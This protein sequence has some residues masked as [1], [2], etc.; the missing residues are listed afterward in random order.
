[1]GK[2]PDTEI[3]FYINTPLTGTSSPIFQTLEQRATYWN[4]SRVAHTTGN[5]YVRRTTGTLKVAIKDLAGV[6]Y[7]RITEISWI[8]KNY[9]NHEFFAR[10]A[11]F[12][13]VSNGVVEFLFE[14]DLPQTWMHYAQFYSSPIDR[15][16]LTEAEY[17]AAVA[18]PWTNDILEMLTPEPDL[19]VARELEES[20]LMP[21]S[22]VGIDGWV[23]GILPGAA[24]NGKAGLLAQWPEVN[25][26][27]GDKLGSDS[28]IVIA[29]NMFPMRNSPFPVE[30]SP[31][32]WEELFPFGTVSWITPNFSMGGGVQRRRATGGPHYLMGIR[33]DG[34]AHRGGDIA[35]PLIDNALESPDKSVSHI[36]AVLAKNN[37]VHQIVS[38]PS[39]IPN[40]MCFANL[41]WQGDPSFVPGE[42]T[43][44]GRKII[45]APTGEYEDHG[46]PKLN[47]APFRYLRVK[48]PDGQEV[49]LTRERF[50][51]PTSPLFIFYSDFDAE[52]TVNCLPMQYD[53][54]D[55]NIDARLSFGAFPV[56]AIST[57]S[58]LAALGQ[59]K[60][61]ALMGALRPS[62]NLRVAGV[63]DKDYMDGV[64]SRTSSANN[65]F[66]AAITAGMA[67]AS[68]GMKGAT[69]NLATALS[70][71]VW[72]A[73]HE[74]AGQR[75]TA[76]LQRTVEDNQLLKSASPGGSD[77]DLP[78]GMLNNLKGAV[79]GTDYKPGNMGN[80]MLFKLSRM[81]FRIFDVQLR[82]VIIKAYADYFTKNGYTSGRLGVPKVIQGM[83]GGEM[84]RFE[85]LDGQLVTYVK[86]SGLKVAGV[87]VEARRAIE[88]MFDN[89]HRFI[90]GW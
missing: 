45:A 30:N 35:A 13:I 10:V 22:N 16:G 66:V 83:R 59:M 90:K 46:H 60:Q 57:D 11:D 3:D 69:P 86:T 28:A 39:I 56:M 67:G 34:K 7:A 74:Y 62:D 49:A 25:T 54:S 26:A 80:S 20:Y 27:V 87:P 58:Y 24:D 55:V 23:N 76:D 79:V 52:P 75:A 44:L 77:A 5:L 31:V 51:Y 33:L 64:I 17:A 84:P 9:E 53:G 37:L 6:S 12:N 2:A 82:S 61:E 48:G 78:K 85:E 32:D 63:G 72:E 81:S 19:P 70:G 29:M 42:S 73:G 1:M 41:T 47:R 18:N 4:N 68:G 89:G 38:G 15:E 43:I 65:G 21:K 14:V 36:M 50:V 40:E 8:N 88:T 71:S